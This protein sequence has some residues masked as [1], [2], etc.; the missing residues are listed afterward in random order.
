MITPPSFGLV[1]SV[2]RLCGKLSRS[3]FILG[4]SIGNNSFLLFDIVS[5]YLSPS[6]WNASRRTT[7]IHSWRHIFSDVVL[8]PNNIW[9][10]LGKKEF[11]FSKFFPKTEIWWNVLF[12]YLRHKVACICACIC[13]LSCI[14]LYNHLPRHLYPPW[15]LTLPFN[16]K[17]ASLFLRMGKGAATEAS[18]YEKVCNRKETTK[19][20]FAIIFHPEIQNITK[21]SFL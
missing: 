21:R 13:I 2:E 15:L 14:S 3:S 11:A 4:V 7:G 16:C 20:A 19:I 1:I 18:K 8:L 5:L 12:F 17:K 9:F 10:F 6:H